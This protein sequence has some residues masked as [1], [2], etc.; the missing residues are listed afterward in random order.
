LPPTPVGGIVVVG[1][2][3]YPF[4]I[5]CA[6]VDDAN[7]SASQSTKIEINPSAARYRTFWYFMNDD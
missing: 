2:V 5:G 1:G 3:K 4:C 6:D 7:A